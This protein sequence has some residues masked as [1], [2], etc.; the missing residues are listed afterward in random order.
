MSP[1]ICGSVYPLVHSFYEELESMKIFVGI[2]TNCYANT[3]PWCRTLSAGRAPTA[4]C[5][6]LGLARGQEM[7]ATYNRQSL[8]APRPGRPSLCRS[9]KHQ[10][11]RKKNP[12]RQTP[13]RSAEKN[14]SFSFYTPTDCSSLK[15]CQSEATVGDKARLGRCNHL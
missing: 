10:A 3:N 4:H 2:Q 13:S 8:G 5:D 15:R 9:P 14:V 11:F 1:L 6:T 7:F 12:S